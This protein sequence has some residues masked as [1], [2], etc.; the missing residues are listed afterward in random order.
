MKIGYARLHSK[1]QSLDAQL[2]L[3]KENSCE[4]IY[5]EYGSGSLDELPELRK[6]IEKLQEGDTLVV[7][8]IDRLCGSMNHRIEVLKKLIDGNI[9]IIS[10][11]EHVN[12]ENPEDKNKLQSFIELTEL[13]M[14]A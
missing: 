9:G 8:K 10:I 4:T 13:E 11:L 3:L 2:N 12:T 5:S 1:C 7:S 6:C 14:Q